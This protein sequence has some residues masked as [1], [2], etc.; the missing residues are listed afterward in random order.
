MRNSVYKTLY[1]NYTNYTPFIHN[2]VIPEINARF[3]IM[4]FKG[5]N[6]NAILL[7]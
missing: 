7:M 5:F 6:K 2:T 3:K 4:K 1:T